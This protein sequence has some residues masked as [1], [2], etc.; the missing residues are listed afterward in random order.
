MT[1]WLWRLSSRTVLGWTLLLLFQ[2]RVPA[3]AEAPPHRTV[4]V[5]HSVAPETPGIQE[6]TTGIYTE[7]RT[8]SPVPVDLYS[9]YTGL[10]R[11]TG[12]T[13]EAD[14]LSL[15]NQKYASRKVDLLVLVGNNALEFAIAHKFLEGV[16]IVTCYIPLKILEQAQT[17]RPNITGALPAQNA[18]KNIECML[19]MF[20]GTRQIDVILGASTYE[21]EQARIGRTIFK[22]FEGRVTLNYLNDLSLEQMERRLRSL[23]DDR[24]VLFGSL[25]Q[26]A[27]GRDF[28]TNEPLNR[29]S[30]VS[31]RPIFGLVHEDLGDGI[32][33]GIL[34]SMKDSG[35]AAAEIG[36]K[37]MNGQSAASIPPVKD[38]GEAPIWDSRELARWGLKD[39]NLPPGSRIEFR[40]PSLWSLYWK[41][42]STALVLIIGEGLLVAA[43]VAQL[44]RR[45]QFERALKDAEMRYRTVADFAHDWEYWILPDGSL[46]YVSPACEEVS[47]YAPEELKA[48]P[49]LLERMVI[50]EDLPAWQA[51]QAD[52]LI[53]REN[54]GEVYRILTKSHEV[55]WM[56]QFSNPIWLNG[57]QFAGTR[58]SIRDITARK[59]GELDLQNAYDEIR[60]LKDQL[61][62][63]N[64]YY[65]DKIQDVQGSSEILGQSDAMKYLHFRINQVALSDTTVLIQG[66]TGT[67]KELVAEAIHEL[68]PRKDR[69]LVKINCAA[70]PQG[71]AESELFGHEKGAFTG[72]QSRR[73]GRFE[74]ADGATL[75]MDEVGELSPEIQA[76]LLRVLQD[77][78]FQRVGGDQTI[79]VDVRVIAATNRNLLDE[80]KAGRFREDLWYRLNVFLI[81]VPTLAQR[82]ED[83]PT[84]AQ[85]FVQRFCQRL[86][87]PVLEISNSVIQ[88]LQGYLWPGNVRELQNVIE[89]AVLVSDGRQ[90]RLADQLRSVPGTRLEGQR[91]KTLEEVERQHILEAL[92]STQWRV[93][94]SQGA[95]EILGL[96]PTTL[97]SRMLKLNITKA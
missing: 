81:T 75:F 51:N 7:L 5:L 4:V 49:A 34:L 31:R 42:I 54:H 33:G 88:T 22:D 76:K 38:T 6:L 57:G 23:P 61:E 59:Q 97:R 83:I 93:S 46:A 91:L 65:R 11:F 82:K 70:L 79:R 37:V 48:D 15:Y 58:G 18:P 80:V 27:T 94:G 53:G 13:Y 44:Q 47:G 43:L 41:E 84:L 69:P 71:L 39:R 3:H 2:S 14:L 16:P 45:K 55:R 95:A 89:Q 26:D 29:L 64:T 10:D 40:A 36:L 25:I 1:H 28:A 62:A 21:R 87:R 66:A 96:K 24:L 68:G 19:A 52:A 73:K 32:L 35:I 92:E 20:P 77:G 12:P 60:T 50:K 90:L 63:E 85:A 17:K 8:G 30:K 74:V 67:G 56:E 72:A 78:E 9:E 86:G